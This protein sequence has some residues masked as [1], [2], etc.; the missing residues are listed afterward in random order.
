ML[1]GY[2]AIV[3]KLPYLL[4]RVCLQPRLLPELG[5]ADG[6]ED[7]Q[8]EEEEEEEPILIKHVQ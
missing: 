5:G 1:V 4:I 8:E 7:E 6:S 3:A 2:T